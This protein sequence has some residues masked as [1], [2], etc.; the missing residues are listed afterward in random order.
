MTEIIFLVL[1]DTMHYRR[2]AASSTVAWHSINVDEGSQA[3]AKQQGAETLPCCTLLKE[4]EHA[5]G[6]VC[7]RHCSRVEAP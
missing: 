5:R 6:A 2:D 1:L 4:P 7:D 3:A